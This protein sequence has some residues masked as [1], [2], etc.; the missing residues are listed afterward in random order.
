MHKQQEASVFNQYMERLNLCRITKKQTSLKSLSSVINTVNGSGVFNGAGATCHAPLVLTSCTLLLAETSK[1]M[2]QF[3]EKP[4]LLREDPLPHSLNSK[5]AT[6][7]CGVRPLTLITSQHGVSESPNSATTTCC[8]IVRQHVVQTVH[9]TAVKML[10]IGCKLSPGCGGWG[11]GLGRLGIEVPNGSRG[12]APV[13]CG[14][15]P[16]GWKCWK[17][18]QWHPIFVTT[19]LKSLLF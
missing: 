4:H 12:R 18:N 13:E 7:P 3:N 10:L 1:F 9:C 14:E 5:Y 8:R 19:Q 11:Q 6:G 17:F 16:P 15:K 2:Y